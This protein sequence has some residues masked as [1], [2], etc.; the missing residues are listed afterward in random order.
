MQALKLE[1]EAL[2]L[3]VRTMEVEREA[4]NVMLDADEINN[5]SKF[6]K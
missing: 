2:A 1:I 5:R 3:E 4:H 6:E